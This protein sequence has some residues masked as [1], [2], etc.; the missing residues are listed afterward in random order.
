MLTSDL[1]KANSTLNAQ[2]RNFTFMANAI[3]V[4]K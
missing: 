2:V 1:R 4:S 3:G